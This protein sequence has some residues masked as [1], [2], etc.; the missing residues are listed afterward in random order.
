MEKKDHDILS[1]VMHGTEEADK[2][3]L[4]SVSHRK[5]T[6]EHIME[7]KEIPW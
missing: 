2:K 1:E 5:S 4:F 7:R 6:I 3:L